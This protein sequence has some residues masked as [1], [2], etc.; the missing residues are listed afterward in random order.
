MSA[1]TN[2]Q[3]DVEGIRKRIEK[4]RM[5]LDDL[6]LRR[7]TRAE[8]A[9]RL[10]RWVDDQASLVRAS[11]FV[12]TATLASVSIDGSAFRA[13]AMGDINGN[14]TVSLA[15]YLCWLDPEGMKRRLL[16]ELDEIADERC[17]STP[18]KDRKRALEQREAKLLQLE[19]DEE[20]AIV[21]AEAQGI[22]IARRPDVRPDV[23][24]EVEGDV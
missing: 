21:A 24:L 8:T 7:L 2:Y 20:A 14:G 9:E 10:E 5:D 3:A 17:A 1:T 12:S 23:V 13:N 16:A 22:Q 15:P 6:R 19:R 18:P 4:A 11:V